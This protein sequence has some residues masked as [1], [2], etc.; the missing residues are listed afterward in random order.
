MNP[1]QRFRRNSLAPAP[2]PAPV[3][4]IEEP[5]VRERRK[6]VSFFTP[7]QIPA[8]V[9]VVSVPVVS[10][11]IDEPIKGHKSLCER[12]SRNEKRLDENKSCECDKVEAKFKSDIDQVKK[13]YELTFKKLYDEVAVLRK[14]LKDLIDN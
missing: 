10:V 4:D 8:P 1:N 13:Q 2:I 12:V 5:P 3:P 6:S 9:P 7:P 11:P 14:E